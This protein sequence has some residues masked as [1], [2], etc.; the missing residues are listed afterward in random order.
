MTPYYSQDGIDIYL[1]DCRDILP[2]FPDKSFDLV[3]TDP[4]YGITDNDWDKPVD[5]NIWMIARGAVITASEP[6]ATNVILTAPLQFKYDCVWVKNCTSN[7]FN[8]DY[9]PLR[10]HERILIFGEMEW[11]PVRR[12]RTSKEMRRLNRKQR[13]Y[14]GF[15]NPDTILDFDSVNCRAS[16]RTEHQSQKPVELFIYLAKSY[17]GSLQSIL[18]PFMGSGTTL[19][20]A[21][22]L[23]R[24][25]VGIEIEEK[26]CEIAVKRLAQMEMKFS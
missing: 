5:A 18:D 2:T 23:G 19:V 12:K 9:M 25:A 3:L 4:P 7:A 10:R 20:A 24:K 26:Y 14:M 22:Q 13:I 1:G 21:K 8:V 15:A 11:H 17:S 16:K 6:Y